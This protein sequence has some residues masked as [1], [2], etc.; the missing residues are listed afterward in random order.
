MEKSQRI[1]KIY[2]NHAMSPAF[3]RLY[4]GSA[5]IRVNISVFV[6]HT[7]ILASAAKGGK[8][9]NRWGCLWPSAGEEQTH[10]FPSMVWFCPPLSS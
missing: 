3:L 5:G 9:R 1:K 6:A 7:V 2:V 10:L 4:V 8:G